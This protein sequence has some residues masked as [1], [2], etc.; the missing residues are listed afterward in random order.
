MNEK[1]QN[2]DTFKR[3]F[4]KVKSQ[5]KD[6]EQSAENK[7][8]RIESMKNEEKDLT[9]KVENEI[10]TDESV[11]MD[12]ST[13]KEDATNATIEETAKVEDATEENKI[14]VDTEKRLKDAQA[15]VKNHMLVSAGFGA[16]PVP[17]VD[18]IGLTGTQLNMLKDLSAVYGQDFTTELGKKAIASLAGGSFSVPVSIGLS[19]LIKSIP[20]IGQTA[21][22]ISVATIGAAATYAVGE[23]FIKH[24]Q[25]GGTFITFDAT[26]FKD[27]FKEKFS[28]GKKEVEEIKEE[29]LE[30]TVEDNKEVKATA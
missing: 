15:I 27:Y 21:G 8:E 19:S 20:V 1:K 14:E 10:K 18:L 23:V 13:V 4:S 11:A 24:F 17:M 16:V 26:N 28:R 29:T 7:K 25:S 6:A 2:V 22:V 12:S 30:T 9:V 5:G 3:G